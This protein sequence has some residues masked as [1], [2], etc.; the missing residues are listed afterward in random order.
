[1]EFGRIKFTQL[2]GLNTESRNDVSHWDITHVIIGAINSNHLQ[3]CALF[4]IALKKVALFGF[5]DGSKLT[6]HDRL[7]DNITA[8]LTDQFTR[9][10][11]S[12]FRL[13]TNIHLTL[14]MTSA[15]VVKTSVTTND[16]SPSQEYTQP[17]DET[18]VN[19]E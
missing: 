3:R 8:R 5:A 4:K 15:Q 19:K 17:D 12:I 14:M 7:T 6:K 18:T 13:T 10:G 11:L 2:Q 16:N 9:T 1:M